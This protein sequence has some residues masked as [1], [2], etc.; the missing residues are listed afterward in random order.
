MG[1]LLQK[2]EKYPELYKKKSDYIFNYY[3][4]CTMNQST[5]KLVTDTYLF[6]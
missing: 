2:I 4:G 5:Q 6:I 3:I 1:T